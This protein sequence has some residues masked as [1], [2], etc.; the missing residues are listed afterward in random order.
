VLVGIVAERESL[1]ATK[2][3]APNLKTYSRAIVLA[4][5]LKTYLRA[6]LLAPNLKRQVTMRRFGQDFLG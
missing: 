1:V 2:V 5:N 4:A 6:I 3:L